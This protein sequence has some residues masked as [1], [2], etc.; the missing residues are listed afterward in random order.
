MI[1]SS[2]TKIQETTVED[3]PLGAIIYRTT[4]RKG[5][6]YTPHRPINVQRKYR[7]RG[8]IRRTTFDN[9][10]PGTYFMG[11]LIMDYAKK[12]INGDGWCYLYFI[13]NNDGTD[14]T[15]GL[16]R[17]VEFEVGAG[18]DRPF[19]KEAKFVSMASV[20]NYDKTTATYE[21]CGFDVQELLS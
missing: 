15:P 8:W 18:T 3:A 5:V 4:S 13:R 9:I 6:V 10:P 20:V 2:V 19:P 1:P 17:Y 11:A 21:F 12:P 14:L 16:W 7:L